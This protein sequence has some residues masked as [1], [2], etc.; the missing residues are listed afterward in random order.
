MH[1]YCFFCVRYCVQDE[2]KIYISTSNC[3][4]FIVI[5]QLQQIHALIM[6]TIDDH[7]E[8]FFHTHSIPIFFFGLFLLRCQCYCVMRTNPDTVET[9]RQSMFH[10]D[11]GINCIKWI[12]RRFFFSA[13]RRVMAVSTEVKRPK[14]TTTTKKRNK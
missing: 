6:P 10:R 11:C 14:W 7:N 13:Y 5:N 3:M 2:I 8:I 4:L 9:S 12:C 1:L